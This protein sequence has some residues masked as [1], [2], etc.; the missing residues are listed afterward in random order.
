MMPSDRLM[1][2]KTSTARRVAALIG[3]RSCGR[4]DDS[5]LIG[6]VKGTHLLRQM[7]FPD[8]MLLLP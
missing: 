6:D 3:R 4:G 5:R 2:T 1:N 8:R 7:A